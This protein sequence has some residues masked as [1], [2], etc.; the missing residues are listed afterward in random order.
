M[1]CLHVVRERVVSGLRRAHRARRLGVVAGLASLAAAPAVAATFIYVANAGDGTVGMYRLDP[2]SGWVDTLGTVRVAPQV[3]TLAVSADRRQ[4]YA[5]GNTPHTGVTSLAVHATSGVLTH[6]HHATL[7]QSLGSVVADRSGRFLLGVHAD[8]KALSAVPLGPQG[9]ALAEA[10]HTPLAQEPAAIASPKL[11]LD[12]TN[13]WAQVLRP[14]AQQIHT[15][16]FNER[17]GALVAAKANPLQLEP[18]FAP[19]QLVY[20]PSGRH[21]LLLAQTGTR[22]A[23]VAVDAD[24]GALRHLHTQEAAQPAPEGVGVTSDLVIGPNGR[25]AY[26]LEHSTSLLMVLAINTVTGQLR[27]VQTLPVERAPRALA[28]EPHGRQ[29]IVVGERSAEMGVYTLHPELGTATLAR[30]VPVGQGASAVVVVST[31]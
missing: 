15:W 14:G 26:V 16:E 28:I 17:T 1:S 31:P 19:H 3:R 12:A 9:M 7:A 23:S 2:G 13:R 22:I 24:S 11:A 18:N 30:R 20:T 6:L 25:F 5:A 29:L 4:V 8:G 10:Q 27:P 21:A